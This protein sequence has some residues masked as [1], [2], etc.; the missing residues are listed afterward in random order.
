[1]QTIERSLQESP[2]ARATDPSNQGRRDFV[3]NEVTSHGGFAAQR[4]D[5]YD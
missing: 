3:A 5:I 1:M 2:D 4:F